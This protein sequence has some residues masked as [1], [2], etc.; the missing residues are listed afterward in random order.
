[1][2]FFTLISTTYY[3]T[4]YKMFHSQAVQVKVV[5]TYVSHMVISTVIGTFTIISSHAAQILM[6]HK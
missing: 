2:L 3:L 1:M 6:A 5:V 4:K